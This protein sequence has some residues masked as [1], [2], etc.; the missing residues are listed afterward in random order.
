MATSTPMNDSAP[1]FNR[2][3]WPAKEAFTNDSRSRPRCTYTATVQDT[4]GQ[5]MFLGLSETS[6]SY[7]RNAAASG[8]GLLKPLKDGFKRTFKCLLQKAQGMME[9]VPR[10]IIP[11]ATQRFTC[12]MV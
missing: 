2:L 4:F 8:R 11:E 1:L 10:A 3:P 6:S 7:L 12:A 5:V 9:L